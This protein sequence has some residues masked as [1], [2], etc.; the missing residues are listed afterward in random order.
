MV[1]FEDVICRPTNKISISLCVYRGA[2]KF[3][4]RPGRKQAI[5]TEDFEFRISYLRGTADKYCTQ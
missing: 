5:V 1:R 3:L 2:D 4:A